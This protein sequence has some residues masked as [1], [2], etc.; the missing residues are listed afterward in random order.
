MSEKT[1]VGGHAEHIHANCKC[2]YAVRFDTKSDVGGYDPDALLEEYKSMSGRGSEEKLSAWRRKLREKN[3]DTMN[4]QKRVQYAN[5][6]KA[7][8]SAIKEYRPVIL[9]K[10]D[11]FAAK[12]G[13]AEIVALK[14][15]STVNAIRV[16]K[17]AG[18]KR[19]ALHNI[20]LAISESK[21]IVGVSEVSEAVIIS[22]EEMQTGALAAYNFAQNKIYICNIMGDKK[23]I[24]R[25]QSQF[26]CPGDSRSTLVHE[27]IHL[28][29]A[30]EYRRKYGEITE[31]DI[32]DYN[33]Y[34]NHEAKKDRQ[35]SK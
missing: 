22:E 5:K 7:K 13:I 14:A 20:D 23:N 11:S 3:K 6:S 15:E 25:V 27:L 29:D 19:R 1:L 4:A 12:R 32:A 24:E 2:E 33:E 21:E 10:K 18:I 17:D 16:S 30:E 31:K 35:I 34:K 8:A 28:K 9:D 26:A